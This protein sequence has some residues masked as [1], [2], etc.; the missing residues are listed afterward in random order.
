MGM[1]VHYIDRVLYFD[2][3][4]VREDSEN[5]YGVYEYGIDRISKSRE[6]YE[7]VITSATNMKEASQKAKLLQIGY[8]IGFDKA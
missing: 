4:A 2:N 3:F 7:E 6:I 8:N 5:F 1:K